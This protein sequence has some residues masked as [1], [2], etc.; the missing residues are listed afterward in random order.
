MVAFLAG[1]EEHNPDQKQHLEFPGG[2]LRLIE[3][4]WESQNGDKILIT[5]A[6]L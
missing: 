5:E 4:A 3:R 1:M 2:T 6:L